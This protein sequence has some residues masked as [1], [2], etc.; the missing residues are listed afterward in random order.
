MIRIPRRLDTE[1]VDFLLMGVLPARVDYDPGVGRIRLCFH[2]PRLGPGIELKG[3]LFDWDEEHTPVQHVVDGWA[4]QLADPHA[5]P[6][7]MEIDGVPWRLV[8]CPICGTETGPDI[9]VWLGDAG[10]RICSSDMCA[11]LAS[12]MA[13]QLIALGW[14]PTKEVIRD[15]H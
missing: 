2:D 14:Q 1:P 13:D 7:E 15:G 3:D 5:D 8:L 10:P 11:D 4:E 9:E 12:R 6:L